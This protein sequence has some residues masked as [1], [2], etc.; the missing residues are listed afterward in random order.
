MRR[1]DGRGRRRFKS[2]GIGGWTMGVLGR[3]GADGVGE[4]RDDKG[5]GG[6]LR[7]RTTL[8]TMKLSPQNK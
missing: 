6:L 1:L 2:T 4:G 3:G 5:G 8:N 7:L